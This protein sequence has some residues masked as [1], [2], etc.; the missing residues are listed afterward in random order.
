VYSSADQEL[1]LQLIER[2]VINAVG[3]AMRLVARWGV[4]KLN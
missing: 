3:D 4:L 2:H 1:S